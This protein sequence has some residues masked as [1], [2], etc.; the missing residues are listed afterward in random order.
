[1]SWFYHLKAFS[2]GQIA[3]YY[4]DARYQKNT[5]QFL[6]LKWVFIDIAQFK[7]V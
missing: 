2:S 6:P 7:C 5:R 1:M 4:V 3:Q